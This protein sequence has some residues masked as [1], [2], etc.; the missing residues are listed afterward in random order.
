MAVDRRQLLDAEEVCKRL[1][2]SRS[3]LTRL[4]RD[5]V[6][7][8]ANPAPSYLKRPRRLLFYPEDVTRLLQGQAS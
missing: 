1:A 4:Q 6:L 8:P 5:N 2:I 3:T 7:K